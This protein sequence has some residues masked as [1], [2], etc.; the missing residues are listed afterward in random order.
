MYLAV[1]AVAIIISFQLK[2]APT[3]LERHMALPLGIIFWVL[4]LACLTN[5]F[6]NY[7]RTVKKYSLKAALVQSGW[8][9]QAVYT[10]LG[11]VILGSCILFLVT[12]ANK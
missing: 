3:S 12:D 9:T 11:A 5:G 10:I 6:A 4:S 1:V 2:G 7:V 8:K